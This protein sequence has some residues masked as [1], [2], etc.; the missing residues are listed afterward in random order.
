MTTPY[1]SDARGSAALLLID[2]DGTRSI[3]T[4]FALA[5]RH[6]RALRVADPQMQIAILAVD[7]GVRLLIQRPGDDASG[8]MAVGQALRAGV[9]VGVCRYSLGER[10]GTD[11]YEVLPGVTLVDHGL[12]EACRLAREG[13]VLIPCAAHRL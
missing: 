8:A 6:A 12:A 7:G 13:Y 3:L 10:L 2:D 11:P 5:L 1:R 9:F 4:P